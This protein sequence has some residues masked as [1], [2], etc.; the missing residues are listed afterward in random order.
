M[1]HSPEPALAPLFDDYA[2]YYDALYADKDYQAEANHVAGLIRRHAPNA[3]TLLEF[4][5]GT[6][7]HARLLA[8]MGYQV[9]GV[10]RSAAML[11][12]QASAEGFCC[13][14][15]DARHIRYGRCFDAVL[16]LFHVINYQRDDDDLH[17]LLANAAR[18]LEPGGVFLFD[19]WYTP[20]VLAHPPEAR[21]KHARCGRERLQRTAQPRVHADGRRVDVV[22]TLEVTDEATAHT[23]T[24]RETHP[25]RHFG[26]DELD[27]CAA[28]HGFERLCAHEFLSG[29]PASEDTWGVCIVMRKA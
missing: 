15:G 1:L 13:R 24:I 6:G 25:M 23:H 20:A 10:E 5:S 14:L 27:R 12:H 9:E 2:R 28:A 21:V 17:A 16:A 8:D 11:A 22:Y 26:L 3:R 4:G 7:H 19:T 29:R 18:H